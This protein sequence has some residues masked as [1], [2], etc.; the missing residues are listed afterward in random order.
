M[1]KHM[2]NAHKQAQ[3][4]L[5]TASHTPISCSRFSPSTASPMRS[6]LTKTSGCPASSCSPPW[7]SSFALI[8]VDILNCSLC[9][10]ANAKCMIGTKAKEE[11]AGR[12]GVL[13]LLLNLRRNACVHT[14]WMYTPLCN[15]VYVPVLRGFTCMQQARRY[16]GSDRIFPCTGSLSPC[17]IWLVAYF[18]IPFLAL[19]LHVSALS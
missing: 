12:V 2:I 14:H 18:V 7:T 4:W 15:V 19:P 3:G 11:K 17:D 10:R 1:V 5:L 9:H 16:W 13:C 8:P 6:G